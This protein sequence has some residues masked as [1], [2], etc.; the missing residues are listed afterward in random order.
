MINNN[1]DFDIISLFAKSNMYYDMIKSTFD[2]CC[3]LIFKC[4]FIVCCFTLKYIEHNRTLDDVWYM[5]KN[6]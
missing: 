6:K 2:M 1:L 3:F 4:I 5:M